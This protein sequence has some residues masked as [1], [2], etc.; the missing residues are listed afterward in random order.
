[1]K[2]ILRTPLEGVDTLIWLATEPDITHLAGAFV[3]DRVARPYDRVPMT[4][5]SARDR[6]LLWQAVVGLAGIEDP[7]A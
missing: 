6:R 1:M 5:V 7:G 3:H 2:P 4:R